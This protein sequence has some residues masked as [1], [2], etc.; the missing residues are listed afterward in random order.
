MG[1]P[2][3]TYCTANNATPANS[4]GAWIA[5]TGEIEKN[6]VSYSYGG[7][8][9][10]R[11]FVDTVSK[12][13]APA[14]DICKPADIGGPPKPAA[15]VEACT[16]ISA[17]RG[18]ID[19]AA[20]GGTD[21]LKNT[22]GVIVDGQ[23]T[24]GDVAFKWPGLYNTEYLSSTSASPYYYQYWS[25]IDCEGLVL[26]SL[27]YAEKPE[28]Y[29]AAQI[30]SAKNAKTITGVEL[31][32]ICND[33]DESQTA[34]CT[35]R[36]K[37]SDAKGLSD[38][39]TTRFWG[40][41]NHN[42]FYHYLPKDG[43]SLIKRGDLVQ[44]N[45]HISIVHSSRFGV[46]EKEGKYD[47]IH[48]SGTRCIKKDEDNVCLPGKFARKVLVTKDSFPGKSIGFGRMKLWN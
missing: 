4:N 40:E 37:V 11:Q 31:A 48:A 27:R 28:T 26:N 25:G 10:V 17:Y 2:Y 39:N 46:S 35:T 18:K 16:Y 15:E 33:K 24:S 43:V 21:S 42:V 36:Y 47:I 14:Q 45:K 6:A 20:D 5:R 3:C 32:G 41:A 12:F 29:A 9:T 1:D 30:L 44:Y 19:D 38:T 22:H 13:N 8:R 7:R 34:G 23:Y